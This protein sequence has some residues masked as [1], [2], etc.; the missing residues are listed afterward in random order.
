MGRM[1]DWVI[2]HEENIGHAI[3]KGATNV[4]DVIA[5]CKTNM[6]MVDENYV[7]QQWDEFMGGPDNLTPDQIQNLDN[8]ELSTN[9]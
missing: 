4:E 8:E 9:G 5:Y 1:S 3:E 7:R 2:D 6:E